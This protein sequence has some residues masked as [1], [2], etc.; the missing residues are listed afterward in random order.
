MIF[1]CLSTIQSSRFVEI[2]DRNLN[3]FVKFKRI[4]PNTILRWCIFLDQL[5]FFSLERPF[6]KISVEQLCFSK[7]LELVFYPLPRLPKA[8]KISISRSMVVLSL[9]AEALF[10]WVLGEDDSASSFTTCCSVRETSAGVVTM[11]V[12]KF[13]EQCG[14]KLTEVILIGDRASASLINGE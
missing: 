14:D 6:F 8:S 10:V 5:F 3:F 12:D 9:C 2:I 7:W 1:L 13:G 4:N 11:V